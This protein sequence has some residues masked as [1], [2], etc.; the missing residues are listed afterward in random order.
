MP[1][2]KASSLN[3]YTADIIN[4]A[5][6][7]SYLLALGLQVDEG[8]ISHFLY[9]SRARYIVAPLVRR[10]IHTFGRRAV[11]LRIQPDNPVGSALAR[12]HSSITVLHSLLFSAS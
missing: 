10:P 2:L 11:Q 7:S 1:L 8:H 6:I 12:V 5:T 3:K 4:L 9:E